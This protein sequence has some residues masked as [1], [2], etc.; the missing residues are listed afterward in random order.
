MAT[1]GLRGGELSAPTRV[2]FVATIFAGSF[3]LF[4]VQPMIQRW[5]SLSGGGDPY[6]LYAAS[7]VGSFCGLIAYPLLVEPLLPVTTQRL[8]WSAGY[9][10]LVLLVAWCAFTLPA[11]S[12]L[13]AAAVAGR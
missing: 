5:Y 3:L 12:S 13:R 6:P 8:V 4:L 10:L 2:R 7:N 11:G 1:A 9:A